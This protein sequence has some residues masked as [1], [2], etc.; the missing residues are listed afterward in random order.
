MTDGSQKIA[1]VA[2]GP[3]DPDAAAARLHAALDAHLAAARARSGEHDPAVQAAYTELRAAAAAYDDALYDAFSEVTPFDLD[4][5][6]E[7]EPDAA[8]A[9]PPGPP[10][11]SILAR[12]DYTVIAPENLL[13][14]ASAA[15]GQKI[16]ELEV[17]L[18]ALVDARGHG[19]LADISRALELGLRWHGVTTSIYGS[20]DA[21]PDDDGTEWMEDAF[22]NADPEE[23]LC[24]VDTPVT[25]AKRPAT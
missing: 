5:P 2:D 8:P 24:R 9:R 6:A 20:M 19:H 18:A 14:G 3:A 10:R 17:A 16:V 13:A 25:W 4:E 7:D 1:P 11:M 23:M 22:A 15:V 12:W 21:G